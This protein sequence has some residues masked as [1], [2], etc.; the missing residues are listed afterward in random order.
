MRVIL[1]GAASGILAAALGAGLLRSL[2]FG[3]DPRDPIAFLTAVTV[4]AMSA[5]TAALLAAGRGA[6][7]PPLLALR[8]DE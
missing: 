5:A 1:I 7:M 3:V 8:G 6:A 2:L 4:L